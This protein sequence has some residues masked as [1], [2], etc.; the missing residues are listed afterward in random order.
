MTQNNN[1]FTEWASSLSG[2]NGGNPN[3]EIWV[4]GIESGLKN[5]NSEGYYSGELLNQVSK[6][7][8]I[9]SEKYD[10]KSHTTYKYGISMAKL[11]SAIKG[12]NV[13]CY[14][15]LENESENNQIFQLNLYPI[16]FN[17]TK[18]DLWKQHKMHEFTGFEEKHLFK[19]WCFLHRFPK[20]SKMVSKENY[21]PKLIIGTG[22]NYITDFFACFAGTSGIDAKIHIGEIPASENNKKKRNYYWAKLNN[23]TVLVV[24]PFFSSQSGLH[25]NYLLQK[26]GEE[27]RKLVP[28]I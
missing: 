16:A 9:P 28:S 25:S 2:C 10:W 3:A 24:V 18:S 15:E 20:I 5:D 7:A 19:T 12:R 26:M 17:S 14:K 23:G 22:I 21:S 13:E 11:Y 6:G 1:K 8:F 4:C 27:I